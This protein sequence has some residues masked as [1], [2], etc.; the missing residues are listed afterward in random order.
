MPEPARVRLGDLCGAVDDS[1][2]P[3]C[4]P[5]CLSV[6]RGG[7]PDPDHARCVETHRKDTRR[8]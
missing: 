4:W 3:M 1:E 7:E 8:G 2:L 5:C 6:E